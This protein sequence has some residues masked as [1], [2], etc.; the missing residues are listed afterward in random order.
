VGGG[1]KNW[2]EEMG[3]G[4]R[5]GGKVMVWGLKCQKDVVIGVNE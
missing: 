4:V 1:R 3:K 2:E 5:K